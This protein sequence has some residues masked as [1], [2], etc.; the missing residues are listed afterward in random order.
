MKTQ[1]SVQN[2]I[3]SERYQVV[4]SGDGL[5]RITIEQL[6]VLNF[7]HIISGLDNISADDFNS[8]HAKFTGYTEWL[9]ES[10]SAITIG[11]DWHWVW[12]NGAMKC[13]LKDLPRSNLQLQ[14]SGFDV[15][16]RRNDQLLKQAIEQ[17]SWQATTA[18]AIR[19]RYRESPMNNY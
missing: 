5:V 13:C 16:P 7:S 14:E 1:A 8:E 19:N 15:S 9:F 3:D 11:W 17:F 12:K 2:V 18:A 10:V 6:S 4:P